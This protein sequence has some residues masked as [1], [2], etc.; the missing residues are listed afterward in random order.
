ML[1]CNLIPYRQILFITLFYPACFIVGAYIA[2]QL[3]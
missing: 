2:E 3:K 1:K